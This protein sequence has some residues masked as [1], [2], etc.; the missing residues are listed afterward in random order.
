MDVMKLV[1]I[2]KM[3]LC[4]KTFKM[5]HIT[6]IMPVWGTVY[7]PMAN[8]SHGRPSSVQNL[9]YLALAIPDVF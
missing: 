9:Q 4:L 2:S 5:G 7:H 1:R 8:T 6:L 3:W